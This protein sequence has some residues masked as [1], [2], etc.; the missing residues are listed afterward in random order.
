M[1]LYC[2]CSPRRIFLFKVSAPLSISAYNPASQSIS[3]TKFAYS[4]YPF[5]QLEMC[6]IDKAGLTKGF[7]TGITSTCLGDNQNGL[8]YMSQRHHT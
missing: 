4:Y 1:K 7:E 6:I 8:R 2:A 5:R 3:F